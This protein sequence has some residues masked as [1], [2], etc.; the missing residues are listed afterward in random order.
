MMTAFAPHPALRTLLC[1]AD[2]CL[3]PSEGA[4]YDAS[5]NVTNALLAELGISARYTAHELRL[6]YSGQNFR[7]T[8]QLL[9]ARHGARLGADALDRWVRLEQ[10]MV[11]RHLSEVL[12]PE[13][14]TLTALSALAEIFSLAVVSP[15]AGARVDACIA[16]SGQAAFFD[17][18]HRFS[19]EDSLAAPTSKPDPAIYRFA[20]EVLD[21]SGDRALAVDDSPSG[22]ASAT[23]AG[24][25]AVGMLEFVPRDQRA[26]RTGELVSAG[27]VAVFGSWAELADALGAGA[28]ASSLVVRAG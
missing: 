14:A 3:F 4:A 27:A 22:V 2:G 23:A 10:L 5:V 1:D 13:P 19:A 11:T 12:R 25:P 16:A 21:V 17:T 28:P 8:A 26:G 9:A 6:G 20:G 18:A 24:F 7:T 15:H